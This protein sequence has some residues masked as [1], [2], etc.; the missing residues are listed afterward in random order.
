MYKPE[1]LV[2]M[3]FAYNVALMLRDVRRAFAFDVEAL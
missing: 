2:N 3:V 1:W